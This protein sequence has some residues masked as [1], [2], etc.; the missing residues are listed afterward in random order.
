MS[1]LADRLSA[2][3]HNRFIGRAAELALFQSALDA[4]ELPFYLLLVHGPGG[5]GKTSLLGQFSQLAEQAGAAVWRLDA[6]NF[7]PTPA[8]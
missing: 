1:R 6:R 7:E 4:D 8:A 2:A 5:V 3:R